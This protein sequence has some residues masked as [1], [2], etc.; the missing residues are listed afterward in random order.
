MS[1]VPFGS[2]AVAVV[3]AVLGSLFSAA[4]VAL[5]SL[6][7]SR[8]LVL[9]SIDPVFARYTDHR[10][11]VLSRW[12]VLRV[13]T[14]GL[15]AVVLDDVFEKTLGVSKPMLPAL[16]IMLLYGASAEVLGA[17]ARRRPEASARTALVWL[18]PLEW[19]VA[20]FAA[21]LTWLGAFIERHIEQEHVVDAQ[22]TETEL[23]EAVSGGE[24]SGTLAI[25]PAQMIRN[26]ID[27]QDLTA[28]DVMVPRRLIS[29]IDV[30]T[31]LTTVLEYVSADGHSRYP[32]YRDTVDHIQGLL[33]VKDLFEI[34]SA[35]QLRLLTLAS[36]LRRPVLFVSAA[37][38]V[39]SVLREMRAKRLHLAVVSDEFGGTA[40]IV[41]LE[42]IIEEIVC[43]IHDEYDTE[44]DGPI[45][46][47]GEGRFIASAS[48]ALTDVQTQMGITLPSEGDFESLGGLI[49][50]RSGHVPAAGE[51]LE[52]DGVRLTVREADP[53]RIV[54][55]EI[56]VAPSAPEV[57]S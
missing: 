50:H 42:D 21:P 27:F 39:F 44:A 2:I 23:M 40:G 15:A 31:P 48:V 14:I 28:K 46:K 8:L 26:V 29:G 57:P 53:T 35:G 20:I 47:I 43:E 55:V 6:A 54:K 45:Q 37:Q 33:Y 38:P 56:Q 41:T 19:V 5:T 17:M 4:D 34:V 7:E 18:W 12:L 24:Q 3:T 52:L 36:I 32:V 22:T 9:S 51:V 25:E 1:H 13:T 30:A 49:I 16:V 11:R 10:Q